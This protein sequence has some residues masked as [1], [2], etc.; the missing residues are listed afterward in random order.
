MPHMHGVY[1]PWLVL[2]SLFVS[3]FSATM[4]LQTAKFARRTERTE[5]RHLAIGIGAVALGGGIW[6]MH[7][8]GM[9]A[10][11]LP[12]EISY[13]TLITLLSGL[14]S[15]A[16]SWLA[17]WLLSRVEIN[18][19]Q[20]AVAG[21][22]VGAGIGAMHYSGMAA[23]RM[24]AQMGYEPYT[25]LLSLVVAVALSIFALWLRFGLR[26]HTGLGSTARLLISG[27]VLGLAV[28]GM[29]YIGMAAARFY[30]EPGVQGSGVYLDTT[31]VA[32][33]LSTFTITVTVLVSS[34]NS[35][36]HARELYR[37][38][39]DSKLR[40]KAI[41]DTAIDGVIT[42]DSRGL[43][44]SFSP[45]AEHMFG[46]TAD[47]VIGRNIKMLMPE[48]DKTRHD[49]YL[50]NYLA[51]GVPKIIG[52]G[53]EVMGLRK[54]G[55][56]MPMRL[57]VGRVDLPNELLFVGFVTDIT[58]RHALE[59]SLRET[60]ERAER[61]A[62][63]KS[64]FLANM[65]H[66]I[67]TPMNSIIGFTELLLK[68]E[69]AEVQ[70]SH[71]STVRQSARSL[72]GLL[73]DI[74]DTTRMEKGG[75]TLEAIDFS[76]K[77]L[78][79]QIESSL[80]L[81]AHSKKLGFVTHYPEDM[82][83]YFQGDPLRIQQVL[84][85]LLGNAIK[86]TERGSV[87]LTISYEQGMVHAYIR[88]TGIGMTP[89]QVESIFAPF[90]QADT[91]ISRRFGG[92]GLG[93]TIARQLIELMNG[94]ISVE[95]RLGQGSVFH[96]QLPL[97]IGRK[98]AP[99]KIDLGY[100]VLPSLHILV[101]DDVPQN[102]ELA[103]L[104]LEDHGHRVTT[105][106][107][108]EDA[109]RRFMDGFFDVVL[110]DVHMPITDGLQATRRIREYERSVQRSPVPIIALTASVMAEDQRQARDAGMDGF[111][112]KPLDAN[113]LIGEIA[114]TMRADRAAESDVPAAG[115]PA[116]GP[117]INWHTGS[118]LWGGEARLLRALRSFFDEFGERHALP[119]PDQPDADWEAA[120]FS[121]HSIRGAAGNL[122]MAPVSDLAGHLESL[123]RADKVDDVRKKL[124][125]LQFLLEA[126]ERELQMVER[127][128]HVDAKPASAR[129]SRQDLRVRVQDLLVY[130]E[131]SEF[132]AEILDKVCEGF[133][134]QDESNLGLAVKTAVESFEFTEACILLQDWLGARE[135]QAGAQEA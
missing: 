93:T 39:E 80:K 18:W 75:L 90:T 113:Q 11:Q 126:A 110:M 47:E 108:G 66:E 26:Q 57:A 120:V 132:N 72:L 104:L 33:A 92:T 10:F 64:L 13:D 15:L 44:Q 17:L 115:S 8:I 16:A 50:S 111:A 83:E 40:I 35:L 14:P 128:A 124:P 118:A 38:M 45:S 73:N 76:F 55:S 77:G 97:P 25:F 96:V 123:L 4:A 56:L 30:G 81:S 65:S 21:S 34:L 119:A 99:V 86:F 43:I 107:D 89:Q 116:G 20:L 9:M 87:N 130:L 101:A 122:A 112:V 49:A 31:F 19:S 106:K 7:F 102:L 117:L 42:I 5:H 37:K 71:L 54:D 133:D 28:A 95:S 61:A 94:E 59:A 22:L 23:M 32:L 67:R 62:A 1:N 121:L 134:G 84:T 88:D 12:T 41:L 46:W 100:K 74:L 51:S 24:Q 70:R 91:S 2:L 78:V 131:R 105:A 60:A 36:M 109:V 63:A 27:T 52:A 68:S 135:A 129:M 69:L 127:G 103:R 6:T 114:R 48:P 79:F 125:E 53:R 3:I 82:P 29:H 58:E 85:N 98:P